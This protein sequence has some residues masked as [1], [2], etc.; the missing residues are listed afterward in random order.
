MSSIEPSPG[1]SW[2]TLNAGAHVA[3]VDGRVA[4]VLYS[5][6]ARF[7]DG[8]VAWELCW[9]PVDQPELVDVLFGVSDGLEPWENTWSRARRAVEREL[10]R[11]ESPRK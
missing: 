3:S 10:V 1:I 9:M 6:E 11:L 8:R 4:G 2:R 7:G 5:A